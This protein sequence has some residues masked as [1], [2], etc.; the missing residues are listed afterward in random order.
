M[1]FT[2]INFMGAA[3]GILALICALVLLFGRS[4]TR[5]ILGWGI[6]SI[7]AGWAAIALYAWAASHD[8]FLAPKWASGPIAAAPQSRPSWVPQDCNWN[9]YAA[10][11]G[12]PTSNPPQQQPARDQYGHGVLTDANPYQGMIDRT[13]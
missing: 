7:A 13:R 9:G 8:L 5:K 3:V 11:C 10:V 2:G 12:A 6:A 1:D 4:G